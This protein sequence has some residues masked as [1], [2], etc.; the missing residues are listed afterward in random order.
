MHTLI[1]SLMLG[2]AIGVA[3]LLH[4]AAA[5]SVDLRGGYF[6]DVDLMERE[7]RKGVSTKSDVE[8]LLGPATGAGGAL[9]PR[10]PNEPAEIWFYQEIGASLLGTEG[11]VMRMHAEQ[12]ILMI[13]FVGGIFQGFWWHE[14]GV[15]GEGV[16][17]GGG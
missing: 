4:G 11:G 2:A 1:A 9:S 7:L 12:Q 5:Q 16:L 3:G 8:A 6:P 15:P 14:M 17:G 13:Y 10:A